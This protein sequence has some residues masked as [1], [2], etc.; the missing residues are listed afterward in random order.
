MPGKRF[1]VDARAMLTWGRDSI[2]DHTTAVLELVKNSYDAG[3]RIVEVAIHTAPKNEEEPCIRISDD[4]CG[5]TS[6]ELT[7]NWLRIG[8]SEKLKSK[9]TRLGRRKTGEKGVGRISADRLGA[10]L[11]LRTQA[12]NAVPVGLNVNWNKFEKAGTDLSKITIPVISKP[13]FLIPQPSQ[14]DS[15]KNIFLEAPASRRNSSRLTGTELKITS[16][17][18]QWT[19]SDIED[20]RHE[21]SILTP[22]FERVLDFQVRILNDVDPSLDGVLDSPFYEVAEIEGDFSYSGN[23]HVEY[24]LTDR[25]EKGRIRKHDPITTEWAMFVHAA[26]TIGNDSPANSIPKCGPLDVKLL[27]YPRLAETLRGTDLT[28][29]ELKEFLDT[30]TGIKVYRDNVRVMPYGSVGRP[31]GD[32]LGLGDRKA[33]NPAGPGRIDFRVS[34]NQLVGAVFLTRDGNPRIVDT[35]GREGL[36]HS[37]EFNE[38]KSFLLSGCLPT[39]EAHYHKLYSARKKEE[40]EFSPRESVREVNESLDELVS[41]LRIVEAE[42]PKKAS[43]QV[44]LLRDQISLSRERLKLLQKSSEELASQA[45]IYRG[46]A[47]LGITAATFGHET[48][49]TLDSCLASINTAHALMASG[50][51]SRNEVLEELAKA[52]EYGKRISAWGAFALKRVRRDKRQ[53]RRTNINLLIGELVKGLEPAFSASNIKIRE[54]Y[55]AV[56]GDTFPMDIESVALNL[57]TNAYYFSKLGKKERVVSVVLRNARRE[58][59]NGF[60][61]MVGDS[62]PGVRASIR[63]QVWEPLFSTKVDIDG[64]PFGTGLGLSI[65]DSV[66]RDLGGTRSVD[67]EPRL[68]GA[69]FKIWLRLG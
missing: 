12:R 63:D 37:D 8:Y 10:N 48:E 40:D 49:I 22:P 13:S 32:W 44:E 1:K 65:V 69:R 3:A 17:R 60:E 16:L 42:L 47:T 54:S 31:E 68:E 29:T 61:L 55:E 30:N 56:E 9:T 21:L 26:P 35:S 39:V 23:A 38:L 15:R 7:R 43:R 53:K 24:S 64:R 20:L 28:V 67:S 18:H 57:M 62:G 27:F 11:E 6:R 14:F 46:L 58:G 4:G 45:T 50:T 36:I 41:N 34:P 59:E 25:T 66:V 2:K 5:M 33:R 51:D 19:K 52:I